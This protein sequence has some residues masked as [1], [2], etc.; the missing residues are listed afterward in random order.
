MLPATQMGWPFT[1]VCGQTGETG[2]VQACDLSDTGTA[3]GF[4]DDSSQEM[5]DD[6]VAPGVSLSDCGP[7]RSHALMNEIPPFTLLASQLLHPPTA[8][9]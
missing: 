9:S 8:H 7:S 1:I 5:Q 3:T 2:H 4:E 6:Y